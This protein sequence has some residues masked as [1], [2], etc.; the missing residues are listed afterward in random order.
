[1]ILPISKAPTK[2]LRTPTNPITFPLK[3]SIRRLLA[4]MVDTCKKAE[5]IGLAAPQ[6]GKSLNLALIYLEDVGI[7]AFFLFNPKIVKRSRD[8]E[9]LEEGCLSS[10]GVFGAVER[11]KKITLQTQTPSGEV[12]EE[13]YEGWI[14]RVIQHEVDHL[15]NTLILDKLK[16][17]THG[18]EL[19]EKYQPR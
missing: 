5:G 9:L 12:I 6:I 13:E 7:P 4:D 3:K 15:N 11:P 19:L 16:T 10:P 17:V 18:K 1:M 8:T 14:A 2:V